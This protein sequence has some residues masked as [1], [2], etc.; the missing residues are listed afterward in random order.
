MTFSAITVALVLGG[1]VERMKFSAVM[2][3]AIVW[4]TIVYYPIAH[5]VWYL[6]GG[7]AST[8]IGRASCRARVCQY[9]SISVGAVSLKKKQYRK[10]TCSETR[11]HKYATKN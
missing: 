11:P 1:L 6:G 2:V 5:M 7:D 8:E 4:L 9:V 10:K 3:F